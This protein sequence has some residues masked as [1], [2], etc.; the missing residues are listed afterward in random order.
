MESI[1]SGDAENA[2]FSADRFDKFRVIVNPEYEPSGKSAKGSYYVLGI[3]VGRYR[4]ATEVIVI[5]VSPQPTGSAIKTVVNLFTYQAEDFE[6]Q[7]IKVKKL[8]YRYRARTI[9]V[10]ANGVGAG[11]V[12][13]LTKSQVDPDTGETLLPFGVE[14]GSFEDA[15]APYKH[16][17]GSG[18]EE[19][20]L[21]LIKANVPL[22]SE[23]YA[24]LQAQMFN[25][26]M[27][28]LI[29]E[30]QAK[31]KLLSTK[32]GQAM[33]AVKRNE[34]L[35]PFVLTT[36]LRSQMLNLTEEREGVNIILKQSSRSIPKDKFSA[37]EYGMY[38]IKQVDDI[39]KRRRRNFKDFM[40][41]S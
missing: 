12:D 2:F 3:D 37:L 38:Y 5:K 19:N 23:A 11:F 32:M 33:D 39:N 10:D 41:F 26:K 4:C 40:F 13:F 28:F 22:N 7:A 34:Y 29:D 8:Y 14:G 15:V 21:Y 20:V 31:N 30:V 27:R 25:G 16:V 6:T 9:V 17:R 18:V 24:Y 1:W 36:V 35:Q